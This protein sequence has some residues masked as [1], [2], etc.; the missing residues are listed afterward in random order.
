MKFLDQASINY[1]KAIDAKPSEKYFLDPQ[2]RIEIAIVH[3]K[4]LES[5]K[6]AQAEA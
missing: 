2:Q 4:K 3:Y 5:E 6:S 1:G